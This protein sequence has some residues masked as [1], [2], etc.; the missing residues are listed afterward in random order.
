MF[1]FAF[2]NPNPIFRVYAP[3]SLG[4]HKTNISQWDVLE[5]CRWIWGHTLCLAHTQPT[6]VRS[7]FICKALHKLTFSNIRS[8][9]SCLSNISNQ[10]QLSVFMVT[11]PKQLSF[12]TLITLAMWRNCKNSSTSDPLVQY[13]IF[14]TVS[15]QLSVYHIDN[16]LTKY[17]ALKI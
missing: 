4:Y 1:S 14:V 12:I 15:R 10:Q 17:I 13:C 6:L 8:P 9:S 16:E 5:F 3:R 2:S 11:L 7:T